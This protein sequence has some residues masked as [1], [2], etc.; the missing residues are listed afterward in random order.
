MNGWCIVSNLFSAAFNEN[1]G[2]SVIHNISL[3][4]V[5]IFCPLP[6][7]RFAN[8]TRTLPNSDCYNIENNVNIFENIL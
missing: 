6:S 7:N 1:N 2:K 3:P 8:S 5:R 4:V